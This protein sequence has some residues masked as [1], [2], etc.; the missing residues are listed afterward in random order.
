MWKNYFSR[1]FNIRVHRVSEARQIEI[2][3]A[4]PMV[5]EPSSFEAEIHKPINYIWNK[6]E[7]PQQW[8]ESITIPTY[9]KGD[10]TG[11]HLGISL[12]STS[13]KIIYNILLSRLSP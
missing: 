11:Y 12:L 4:E 8:E 6:E 3:T 9:R 1:L 7:L 5:P 13:Y 10:K 2:D